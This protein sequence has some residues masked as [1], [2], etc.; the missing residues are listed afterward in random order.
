MG[1]TTQFIL[2]N[3]DA[4]QSPVML[5]CYNKQFTGGRFKYYLESF[6]TSDWN[7]KKQRPKDKTAAGIFEGLKLETE[8]IFHRQYLQDRS[9]IT[10]DW[11]KAQV[12]KLI[13]KPVQVQTPKKKTPEPSGL[14]AIW[15][16]VISETMNGDKPI[17]ESTRLSK[18]NNLRWV[19]EYSEKTGWVPSLMNFDKDFFNGFTQYIK[20][21]GLNSGW[22][23]IKD[24]KAFLR[25]CEDR[26]FPVC[27][28][29]KKKFFKIKMNKAEDIYLTE[30]ELQ[31]I[32]DL[33]LP[34]R[35]SD[36]RDTFLMACYCGQ[37]HSDWH[38]IHPDKVVR[39]DDGIEYIGFQQKKTGSK[40]LVPLH[41]VVRGLFAKHGN[42]PPRV[43]SNA[44]ANDYLKEIGEEAKL[45]TV[46]IDGEV[47]DKGTKICTHTARRSFLTN[48]Y[49]NGESTQVLMALSGHKKES[50]FV[51]YL[52]MTGEEKA[53]MAGKSK[54]FTGADTVMKVAV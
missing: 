13:G 46:F 24:L 36:C 21:Q 38:Q 34:K 28:D 29:Y 9:V 53:K 33:E 11:M 12:D 50:S 44:K 39:L 43:L 3:P 4:A 20:S 45:G 42:R 40:L 35:L 54:Y 14:W 8:A 30:S 27:Q 41:P 23:Q 31:K 5:V 2:K 51:S 49:L 52:K 25:E 18:L 37:R 47:Q 19:R 22:K 32:A 10:S 7:E 26:D 16:K 15:E 17:V 1:I 6:N 48:G